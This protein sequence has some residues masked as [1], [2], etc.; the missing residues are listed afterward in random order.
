[1]VRTEKGIQELATGSHEY[2]EETIAG[3]ILC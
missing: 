1:M 2:I 3:K